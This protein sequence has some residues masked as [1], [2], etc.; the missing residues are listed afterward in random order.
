[1]AFTPNI[2]ASGQSLGNSRAQILNNF[3]I[4]R[5]SFGV[6]HVDVNDTGNGKHKFCHLVIQGSDATSAVGEGVLYTKTPPGYTSPLLHYRSPNNGQIIPL[7]GNTNAIASPQGASCLPN[8][9]TMI[10]DNVTA[11]D[12]TVITFPFGGFNQILSLQI[13]G[14][15]VIPTPI[16][17]TSSVGNASFTPMIKAAGGAGTSIGI[18]YLAIGTKIS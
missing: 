4:L 11:T 3:A 6:D 8:G 12:N 18:Y 17:Q 16:I 7:T 5:S 13:T 14:V 1:M 9:L 10:W 2:P 15:G